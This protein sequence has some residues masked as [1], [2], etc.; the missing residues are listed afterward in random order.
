MTSNAKVNKN[1]GFLKN[2]PNYQNNF[3]KFA[4]YGEICTYQYQER[5][6]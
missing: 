3:S 4:H 2:N 6:D 5:F 1:I